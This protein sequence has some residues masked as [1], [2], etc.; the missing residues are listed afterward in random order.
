MDEWAC[1]EKGDRDMRHGPLQFSVGQR[2][3]EAL[4]SFACQPL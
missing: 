1:E 3:W 4:E 2:Y